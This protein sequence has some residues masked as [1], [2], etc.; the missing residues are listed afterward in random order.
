[1]RIAVIGASGTMGSRIAKELQASG[2]S[3]VPASTSTGVDVITREGLDAR[4][5]GVD[6]VVDVVNSGSFGDGDA[7]E[8]FRRATRN[9][10]EAA[11]AA[12]VKHYVALSVMGTDRLVENDYFRGKLV[13]ENIVRSS[14]L[15][16][17]VVRSAQFFDLWVAS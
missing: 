17:T 16:Y 4:L 3:V 5:S 12:G 2:A 9:V 1:M 15:P 7:L 13:Q 8:F 10:V 14:G 6:T 11:K